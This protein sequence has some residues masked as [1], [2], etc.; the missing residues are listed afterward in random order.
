MKIVE[1]IPGEFETIKTDKEHVIYKR[2]STGE[3]F[4]WYAQKGW[5]PC[6][7]TEDYEQAYR[8]FKDRQRREANKNK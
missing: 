5:V 4:R 3:W 8:N 2:L 7:M 6:S 1:I